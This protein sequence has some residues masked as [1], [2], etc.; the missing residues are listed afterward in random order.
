MAKDD[1][2]Q[3]ASAS[4][5]ASLRTAI[6]RHLF[7]ASFVC[8]CSTCATTAQTP[9]AQPVNP[10][11]TPAA[12]ALLH[13]LD[14]ITG[15]ATI[16][17]QHNYP[18]TVSRYSDRVYDLTGEYPGIFGQDF[19]FSGGD[20][21]DSALGRP[22]MIQEVIRQYRNGAVIALTWHAV[23]PTDDEPV[24]FH[25]SVQGHLTDW[26]WHQLLTPGTDLNMRWCRQVDRIAGYLKEL[27]DAGVPVLFRPY[28][29]MNG[30]WFWWGG[31]PGPEGSAALYRQIYDRYVHVH[32]LNNLVWVWNVNS[33]NGNAGPVAD[34]F[35]GSAYADVLTMDIY[36]PF[37]QEF[38]DE[39]VALADPLH[40]TIALAEVGAMP[41]LTTLAQQ[42]R[43]AYF[44]MWSGLAE[45]SNSLDQLQ[46]VFHAPNIVNRGDS[47]L[48]APLAAPTTP[49]APGDI[50]AGA[51]VRALL[52]KLADA[53]GK[54]VLGGQSVVESAAMAFPE[55]QAV[56][57]A[58]GKQPAIIEIDL[59]GAEEP[60]ALLAQV[61]EAARQGE[62]VELRWTPPRPTDG[63]ATGV[64]TSFE[65]QQ[66]LEP[67]TDLNHRWAAQADAA[68]ALLRPLAEAHLAV[69]WSP[70]PALNGDGIWWSGHPG[71]E[72][73]E[74]LYRRLHER[75]TGEA[76][77][78]N[79]AWVWE[80]APPSFNPEGNNGL[81]EFFPGPL[82]VEAIT[83]DADTLGGSR[84]PLDRL[85]TQFA[86]DKPFGVRVASG[87]PAMDVLAREVNWRWMLLS[88][89]A[90][91]RPAAVSGSDAI[92]AFY[93]DP[94]VVA[95][96]Q[97]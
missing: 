79:L 46:T 25:D 29:E 83:L 31:R 95:A 26:E 17:G 91:S 3:D 75:L 44:M 9:D 89:A 35:P 50:H 13:D 11:A 81:E 15:R 76:N 14:T 2:A 19:G 27:Q 85:V 43:W 6:M 53:K 68:A 96:P 20:D 39:M 87:V 30:S 16:S 58:T 12:R 42:P 18:N 94:H 77:L 52:D 34:Y 55:V 4:G 37:R 65:W 82:Y 69:L 33:P 49:P 63:A 60:D 48:S 1:S 74:E 86:G 70:Y 90:A 7:L 88:P 21:K 97:K 59:T 80:A 32:H 45:A 56:L 5:C 38:Y 93:A 71:P 23:R 51:E 78:H 40:K 61:R 67:G 28:H 41:A 92:K 66:L 73:S 8:I 24:T 36:E 72:G 84:F 64:L 10:D 62:L 47:R 54:G 22:S 57:G